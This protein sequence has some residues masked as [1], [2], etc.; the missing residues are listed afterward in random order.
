M[1][2]KTYGLL[3]L[4]L[5]CVLLFVLPVS[6]GQVVTKE[7]SESAKEA[8]ASEQSLTVD[9]TAK[10]IAVL[11]YRN[12]TGNPTFAPL[13]KGMT[14]M[15]ITDLTKL[16]DFEEHRDLQVVE[17]T[18]LQ[19][20][21]E[22]IEL[23]KTGLVDIDTAPRVGKL[24]GARYLASGDILKGSVT[25]L[26]MDPSMMDVPGDEIFE[27]AS[28]EGDLADLISMEKAILFEI[29]RSMKVELTDDQKDALETP[30][31]TNV[32]ALMDYFEGIEASDKGEYAKAAE[33]YAD[34]LA[35]DP[36]LSLAQE[37]IDEIEALDLLKGAEAEQG[38]WGKILKWGAIGAGV[39]AIGVGAYM[40]GE[41]QGEDKA[42]DDQ[43]PPV[44]PGIV[45][46]TPANGATNVS[47]SLADVSIGFS[48]QM[49]TDQ[50]SVTSSHP[51]FWQNPSTVTRIWENNGQTLRIRR[52]DAD[53]NPLPTG[54]QMEFTLDGFVDKDGLQL[55][56]YWFYFIVGSST[57]GSGISIIW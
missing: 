38:K 29:I 32:D 21:L 5:S 1:W 48:K 57:G 53:T 24:L 30:L 25:D 35:K 34:A 22:E 14:V 42:E 10:S 4:I 9:P 15:L 18:R 26:R 46:T 13:R 28:A 20:V 51:E 16:R 31:S 50:G 44:A 43:P 54:T 7:M 11:Y 56:S 37:G 3:V 2:K 52:T 41:K 33:H 8:I 17:R 39:V 12:Q 36:Q 6:A 55:N 40:Y 27:Q 47:P 23:G 49:K 19:A 45:L